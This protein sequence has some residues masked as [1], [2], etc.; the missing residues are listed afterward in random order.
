MIT[1]GC[2][3]R[4]L[5]RTKRNP[6]ITVSDEP[7]TTK[8]SARSTR[9]YAASTRAFGTDS[10]KN[11]TSGLSRPPHC[12]QPT[13]LK[14][15]PVP[16]DRVTVRPELGMLKHRRLVELRICVGQPTLQFGAEPSD[17]RSPGR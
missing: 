16:G 1:T 12:R 6:D 15:L 13:K 5:W 3:S 14:L 10:P 2:C 8:T 4:A 17:L 11:T 7:R 9:A